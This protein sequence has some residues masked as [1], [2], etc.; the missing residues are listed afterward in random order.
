MKTAILA[1]GLAKRLGDLTRDTPKSL[2]PIAGRPFIDHQMA[3]LAR[4][5]CRQIVLCVGHLGHKIREYVGDGKKW[6]LEVE[7]SEDGLKAGPLGTGGALRNALPLLG[8]TFFVT[9]GDSYLTEPWGDVLESYPAPGGPAGPTT[10]FPTEGQ[11]GANNVLYK[12]GKIIRYSKTPG[13]PEMKHIDYGLLILTGRAFQT[14]EKTEFDLEELQQKL[15]TRGAMGAHECAQRFYEAG[16][17]EGIKE[18]EAKLEKEI[19]RP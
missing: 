6:G 4:N 9:Y 5:N 15:I 2:I 11:W 19:T 13:D 8:D 3:L 16:S 10:L 18:L 12:N 7:Y 17:A 1:G 14:V